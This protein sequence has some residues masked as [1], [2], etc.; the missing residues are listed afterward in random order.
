MSFDKAP[1]RLHPLPL[2]LQEVVGLKAQLFKRHERLAEHDCSI[3]IALECP[4]LICAIA[5]P[6]ICLF[7]KSGGEKCLA[8][9]Q[10]K[11]HQS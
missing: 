7:E 2:P 3:A 6:I 5:F 11:I 10:L 4:Y 1:H 9:T 8:N